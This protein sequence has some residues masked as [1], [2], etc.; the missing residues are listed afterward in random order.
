M[1][2]PGP[3]RRPASHLIGLFLLVNL[4]VLTAAVGQAKPG[5]S[6]VRWDRSDVRVSDPRSQF[7]GGQKNL[8]EPTIAIDPTNPKR[9][10]A[11]AIDLSTQN[12]DPDVYST[13]RAFRSSDGG[14]TWTDM[15]GMRWG[16]GIAG[17]DGGDP[18]VFFDRDV[19][20]YFVGLVDPP[21]EFRY[22]YV[23]RSTDAGKAWSK[24]V[25]AVKPIRDE[26]DDICTSADKEWI[27]PG[28]KTGELL[29]TYTAATFTCSLQESMAPL[30]A[31]DLALVVPTSDLGIYLKRSRDGART[32]TETRK[33]WDGY[34]LGAVPMVGL[35]GTLYVAFWAST[36]VS[37]APC[38]TQGAIL[39]FHGGAFGTIVVATSKDDGKTWRT[40]QHSV[41]NVV[42]AS[43]IKPGEYTGGNFLP[44]LAVDQTTNIAYVAYPTYRP[45]ENRFTIEVITSSNG[46][47]TWSD[48]VEVSKPPTEGHLPAL[49]A[50]R[51]VVR[52]VYVIN[53]SDGTGDTLYTQ[54][55]DGG[56]TWSEPFVL[57]TKSAQLEGDPDIGD[58]FT[59]DVRAGRIA[60]IWT[61]AR[62]GSPTE[63][64]SRVGS[65]P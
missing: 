19:T 16:R 9:M 44:A 1:R 51:G 2:G 21:D 59:L 37:T 15:G 13:N 32:W 38:P 11:F 58:Y 54:S 55:V 46:G 63:I 30:G 14:R 39:P 8:Y 26:A 35:D 3:L 61:D 50:D 40:F 34:A 60:T 28:R 42:V 49:H 23:W 10:I 24:P 56:R 6:A 43:L 65:L 36:L 62:N 22:I 5:G 33:I 18:G 57:S 27:S 41:C 20:A 17:L 4:V 25:A 7:A 31:G 45:F 48:P 29:L 52:L 64:W 12:V 47:D 53:R